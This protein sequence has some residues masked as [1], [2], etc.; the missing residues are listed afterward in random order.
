MPSKI[1]LIQGHPDRDGARLCRHLA[2]AYAEGARDGGHELR[3]IDLAALD[4]PLLSSQHAYEHEPIPPG[5]AGAVED[6]LWADHI[7]LVFPLWLGTMPA[8]VKAFL[9]QVLRPGGAFVFPEKGGPQS[10]MAGR[11]ARLVVTMGMPTLLYRFWFGGHGLK[12]IRRNILAFIGIRV[13]RQSLF[14]LVTNATPDKVRGWLDEMR[15][16]GRAAR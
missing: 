11:T 2:D 12:V 1:I 5:L 16:A 9:E 4:F 14:G 7:V 13:V 6:L 15:R 3:R 8:L 10:L